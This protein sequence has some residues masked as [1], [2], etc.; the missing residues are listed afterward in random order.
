MQYTNAPLIP[1]FSRWVGSWQI[2]V[3]RRPLHPE[4]LA[5]AYNRE[6]P[7]WTALTDRLGYGQAYERLFEK[8]ISGRT[9]QASAAPLKVL[10][11]GVGTGSFSLALARAWRMPLALSGVDVSPAMITTA[12]ARFR[13]ANRPARLL[14]A[15]VCALPFAD[16]SFDVVVAAHVLEHL[17]NPIDALNEIRRVLRPGGRVVACMTRHSWLGAYI[18][19]KWRT[20]RLTHDRAHQ[21]LCQAGLAPTNTRAHLTGVA[22]LTSL[23][24]IGQHQ[25]AG[26]AGPEQY[27]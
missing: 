23:V 12:D 6:A 2:R 1:V 5:E 22:G 17:P 21:W 16:A 4:A 26:I 9:I 11:C 24:A 15:C 20:H 18:Q 19:A 27:L 8:L 3:E 7:R 10:D 14:E 25:Q 13:A